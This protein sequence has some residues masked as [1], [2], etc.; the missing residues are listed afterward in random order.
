MNE[1]GQVFGKSLSDA[2]DATRMISPD[3]LSAEFEGTSR[4]KERME[5][6]AWLPAVAIRCME[7]LELHDDEEGIYR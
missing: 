7:Y 3:R 5:A 4:E 1:S 6:M 2:V